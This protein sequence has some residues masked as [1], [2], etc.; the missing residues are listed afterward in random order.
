MTARVQRPNG[1]DQT[2]TQTESLSATLVSDSF[3]S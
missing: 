1:P 3:K 2:L